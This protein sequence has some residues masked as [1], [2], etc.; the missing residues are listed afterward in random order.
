MLVAEF[1]ASPASVSGR[2]AAEEL[3]HRY[4]RA[5]YLWCYRYVQ[6]N[7]RALDLAQDVL[8]SAYQAL[9]TFRRDSK[10]SSWVFA[11]ARNRCLNEVRSGNALVELDAIEGVLS[12]PAPT[13]D[14]EFED[15]ESES[16]LL[17]LIEAVLDPIERR[18]IWLRCVERVPVDQ[19]TARLDIEAASGARGILQSARRK[20]KSAMERRDK[21]A[22][23]GTQ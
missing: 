13:A 16:R 10:F 1:Q 12:D 18:A 9:P 20:L 22:E 7:D 14:R 4:Q 3:L 17:S 21:R 8:L 11:I 19:I 5:T 23:G 15:S 2:D 6:D